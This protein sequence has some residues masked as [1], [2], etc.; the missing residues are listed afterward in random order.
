M[1]V[2]HSMEA[3]LKHVLTLLDH[4]PV[5]VTLGTHLLQMEELVMVSLST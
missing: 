5:A 4:S 1:S 3:V 2:P